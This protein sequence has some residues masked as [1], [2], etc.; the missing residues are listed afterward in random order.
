[1]ETSSTPTSQPPRSRLFRW[2]FWIVGGAAFLVTAYELL[3][4]CVFRRSM[5]P[6]SKLATALLI[7]APV[8]GLIFFLTL[9]ISAFRRRKSLFTWRLARRFL[10]GFAGIAT[11]MALFYAVENWRGKR[12]W[13][14]FRGE[15]EAKGV[16]LDWNAYIPPPV[17]DEQ[18]IFKAPKMQEWFVGR[19]STELSKRS[20]VRSSVIAE[21]TVITNGSAPPAGADLVLQYTDHRLT[22]ANASSNQSVTVGSKDSVIPL[23]VMDDVRLPDAITNLAGQANVKYFFDPKLLSMWNE[24]KPSVLDATVSIR[25]E[26]VTAR[27]ALTALLDNYN[28]ALTESS[29]GGPARIFLKPEPFVQSGERVQEELEKLVTD[30]ITSRNRDPQGPTL[31]SSAESFVFVSESLP[32]I[33]RAHI[34]VRANSVPTWDE[35]RR[36][37]PD[38]VFKRLS[39]ES[40][41][42]NIFHVTLNRPRLFAAADYLAQ[43]DELEPDLALIREALKRPYAR[44]EGDYMQPFAQP[45]PKFITI[46]V[47]SQRLAD[48]AKCYL[49]L[50]QP[51]KALRELTLMHDLR[52]FLEAR[53]TH[54]PMTLVAAMI[55]VAITGLYVNTIADGFQLLA[56][57]E[58]Q[59]KELEKQLAE[60]DLIP[61]VQEAFI[62][63]QA[64][65]CHTLEKTP[66]GEIA[67]QFIA[68]SGEKDTF[69][70]RL[71]SPIYCFL[72]IAPR[73][74]V[75]QNMVV[76][77]SMLQPVINCYDPGR[78][79]IYPRKAADAV[80]A[81]GNLSRYS[82]YTY[83]ETIMLPNYTRATQVLGHH[84]TSANEAMI[85]CALEQY[86]LAHGEYPETLEALVP[87]FIEK[88]P[89]DIVGGEP[90]KYRRVSEASAPNS[91]GKNGSFQLYSI[92]WNE[93]DD[94]GKVVLNKGG[95][96]EYAEGDWTWPPVVK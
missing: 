55:N 46:R 81:M 14:K 20:G 10:I 76:S 85:V 56:W 78:E 50:G 61:I 42:T 84:Q 5:N 75:Y 16:V 28:L 4:F 25:W 79:L 27:Q 45:I 38:S 94:G 96:E 62:D 47:I 87:Q 52:F 17:P 31:K 6:D 21:L 24:R 73:G 82:P 41:G 68:L 12:A 49:L 8:V 2:L 92:G 32:P 30:A 69:W 63:E 39:V 23:L 36:F 19:G 58:P 59:L 43:T 29:N 54:K 66:P 44:M 34:Y 86:R 53:P 71:R 88:V 74:W 15:M 80:K 33:R 48:R 64:G 72:T 65:V 83:L 3:S 91:D 18:N 95:N 1:M 60:I 9:I 67:K 70:E 13:E 37:F 35:L 93:T 22:M 40:A 77:V 7:L 57:S 26:K 90:L 89:H 11:V 51:D